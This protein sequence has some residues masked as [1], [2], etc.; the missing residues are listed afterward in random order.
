L[1]VPLGF[2]ELVCHLKFWVQN[3]FWGSRYLWG[4]LYSIRLLLKLWARIWK[5][6]FWE[7]YA[8][9][10]EVLD[11]YGVVLPRTSITVWLL[12]DR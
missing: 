9:S 12:V 4:F 11:V 5:E 2:W 8:D 6:Y 3:W 1:V 7:N 10:E